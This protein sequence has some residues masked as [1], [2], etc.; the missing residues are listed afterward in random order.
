MTA[1]RARL[2]GL[3]FREAVLWVLDGNSRAESFYGPTGGRAT[4]PSGM[5]FS[6]RLVEQ[7]RHGPRRHHGLAED[8]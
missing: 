2:A 6:G 4:G 7:R 5:R 3:G 1:A 8:P